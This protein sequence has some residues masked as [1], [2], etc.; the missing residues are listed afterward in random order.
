[1]PQGPMLKHIA[2]T[3]LLAGQ[4]APF[5]SRACTNCDYAISVTIED[6]EFG[7]A[8]YQVTCKGESLPEDFACALVFNFDPPVSDGIASVSGGEYD[9]IRG[10]TLRL[11]G[12]LYTA[13]FDPPL[14]KENGFSGVEKHAGILA[15][16][17]GD[18]L[19]VR[20]PNE[21]E[22]K[23]K[24]IGREKINPNRPQHA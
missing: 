22:A 9:L 21:E 11:D 23:A 5:Y 4:F 3:L 8:G 12:T 16:V 20:W 15:K 1:M 10:I 19:L 6:Y 24:I 18:Y 14:K 7:R 17:D 2:S 13:V